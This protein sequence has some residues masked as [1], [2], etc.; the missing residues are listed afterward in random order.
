MGRAMLSRGL[1]DANRELMVRE[2]G[3]RREGRCRG[4]PLREQPRHQGVDA[5][6][7]TGLG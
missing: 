6:S 3:D 1:P 4:Y 7:D 2:P 5:L